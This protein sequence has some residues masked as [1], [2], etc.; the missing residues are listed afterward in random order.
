MD[1]NFAIPLT[2]SNALT[3]NNASPIQPPRCNFFFAH[4]CPNIL[5]TMQDKSNT[6]RSKVRAHRH[7]GGLETAV[8]RELLEGAPWDKHNKDFT[9]PPPAFCCETLI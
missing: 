9:A 4:Y 1:L 6:K 8:L 3:Y 7:S 5:W 2:A